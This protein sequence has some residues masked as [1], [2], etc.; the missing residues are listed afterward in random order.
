MEQNLKLE[1]LRKKIDVIDASLVKIIAK[2][3]RLVKRVGKLKARHGIESLDPKRW[4]KVLARV[5]SIAKETGD[6]S[7]GLV[8]DIWNR[9]HEEALKLEDGFKKK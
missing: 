3:I 4:E 2:R 8:E 9:I 6:I 5:K 7:D 1:K